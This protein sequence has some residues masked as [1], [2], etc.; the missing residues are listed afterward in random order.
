MDQTLASCIGGQILYHWTTSEVP[1]LFILKPNSFSDPWP[2]PAPTTGSVP[3]WAPQ[4]D[5]GPWSVLALSWGGGRT[6]WLM[7]YPMLSLWTQPFL[8]EGQRAQEAPQWAR[9]F[10]RSGCT[11]T[12]SV[13]LLLFSDIPEPFI[14]EVS[15]HIVVV[16]VQLKNFCQYGVWKLKLIVHL[17]GISFI[18]R[19]PA[20]LY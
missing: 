17:I 19:E 9:W 11:S 20:Y 4:V 2:S 6:W 5:R 14:T 10:A 1:S 18:I 8:S 12:A 15:I 3:A 13:S 7:G 16:L